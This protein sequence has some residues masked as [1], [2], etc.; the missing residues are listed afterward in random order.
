MSEHENPVILKEPVGRSG[1][2]V[3]ICVGDFESLLHHTRVVE[4]SFCVM[5]RKPGVCGFSGGVGFF[6]SCE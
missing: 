3:Y 6:F 5:R 1:V 4:S 2:N